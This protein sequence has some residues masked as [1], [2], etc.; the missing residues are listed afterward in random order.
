M[1]ITPVP[2]YDNSQLLDDIQNKL[3]NLR[4]ILGIQ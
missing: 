2:E 4:R 3:T 1:K